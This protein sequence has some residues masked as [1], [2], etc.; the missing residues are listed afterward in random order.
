MLGVKLSDG[1]H[2]HLTAPRHCPA[3]AWMEGTAARTLEG[4]GDRPLDCDQSLSRRFPQA[5]YSP[6][7]VHRVGMFWIAKDLAHGSIFHDLS[8]VH[9]GN[10]IG[11]LC[12]HAQIVC[13][14]HDSHADAFL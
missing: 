1:R 13:D 8:E 3:A 6:K 14:E 2:D 12:D 11:D 7:K 10:R 5:R 4:T 9:N